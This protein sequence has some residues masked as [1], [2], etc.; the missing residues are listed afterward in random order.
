MQARIEQHPDFGDKIE[1]DP[2]ALLEAIRECMHDTVRAQYPYVSV[3]DA[4]RRVLNMKQMENETLTD[5]VRRFKEARD[6][7]L[8]YVGSGILDGFIEQQ[9]EYKNTASAPLK[10]LLKKAA[11]EKWMALV[12]LQNSDQSKY[13]S[14]LQGLMSQYSLEN[15]QYPTTVTA[16]TDILAQHKFDQRYYDMKKRD[17][18][19]NKK[20]EADEAPLQMSFA[21]RGRTPTCYCCG[22][23][24]HTSKNCDQVDTI[25]RNEWYIKKAMQNYQDIADTD[26]DTE[27][28]DDRSVQ[29]QDSATAR[30]RRSGRG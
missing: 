23:P 22:K 14:V 13:G 9:D 29:T 26:D 28:A 5:Y 17:Q 10:E 27:E 2:I 21:Q 1:D 25:P 7:L 11:F 24:G 6:V 12:F 20:P 18:N 15:D 8:S 19:R 4:I 30:H 16:A 3:T